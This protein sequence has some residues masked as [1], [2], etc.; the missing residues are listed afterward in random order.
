MKKVLLITTFLPNIGGG[1]VILRSLIPALKD[2]DIDIEWFYLTEKEVDFPEAKRLGEGLMGGNLLKDFVNSGLL[3]YG[4]KTSLLKSTIDK[5]LSLKADAYWV[6]GHSDGI[7]IAKELAQKTNTPVHLT[8][9][10]D[11]VGGWFG[12]TRRY[13]WLLNQASKMFAEAMHA[14]S[15]VDVVSESM[16]RYYQKM[17]GVDSV[18]VH[19]YLPNLPKLDSKPIEQNTLIVG[20]IGSIYSA[21]EFRLFCEALE[22]YGQQQ[23]LSVKFI[24]IGADRRFLPTD[25]SRLI[26]DI[27]HL[28]ENEAIAELAQ[29]H[30]LYAM[31]PFDNAFAIFRQT[32]LPTKVTTYIQVQRPILAH[33][34][35]DSTLAEIISTYKL[36][37]NTDALTT[38]NLN[39]AIAQIC[40]YQLSEN[41]F[42]V[43]H[44]ALFGMENVNRM[45][46]CLNKNSYQ[47]ARQG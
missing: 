29:C 31:Y 12:R 3:W 43:A 17:L 18:V 32:S 41:A 35:S 24:V 47:P 15:S 39:Q 33:T 9:H 11:L 6:I 8:I 14:V 25:F 34:P 10:D 40:E 28:S 26:V 37:I 22:S 45:A 7:L 44:T 5:I 42:E 30:F 1:S 20:H 13:R 16:R 4:I 36:G 46:T 19:R 38:A 21:H 2:K 27:P 23:G